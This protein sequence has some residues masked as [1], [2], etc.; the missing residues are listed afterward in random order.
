MASTCQI[1]KNERRKALAAKYQERRE[2]LKKM[3]ID[4]NRSPEDRE[5]AARALRA[6]PRN[7][8]KVRIRNRCVVSGRPR[9][10]YRKFGLA[11]VALRD[12]ALRGELPGVTKASW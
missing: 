8:S 2:M 7:S 6:L 12:L 10:Y 5:K 9:G 11:R 3:I 4:P 1:A